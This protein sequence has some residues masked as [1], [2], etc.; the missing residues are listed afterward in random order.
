MIIKR[1]WWASAILHGTM[2]K[3]DPLA[4]QCLTPSVSPIIHSRVGDPVDGDR[5]KQYRFFQQ[6]TCFWSLLNLPI[7]IVLL[8][9]KVAAISSRRPSSS[10]NGTCGYLNLAWWT[11]TCGP[12]I[13]GRGEGRPRSLTQDPFKLAHN[14]LESTDSSPCVG[15]CVAIL[16]S[17]ECEL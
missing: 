9:A 13:R 1:E 3:F 4:F 5:S 11:L 10:P 7:I 14:Y 2:S 17:F 15:C 16:G 6:Y 8:S 12:S